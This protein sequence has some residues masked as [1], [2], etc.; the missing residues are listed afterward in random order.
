MLA[1]FK[2]AQEILD[3]KNVNTC[4]NM[5]SIT[6]GN[7]LLYKSLINTKLV[8]QILKSRKFAGLLNYGVW[9]HFAYGSPKQAWKEFHLQRK[10][11]NFTLYSAQKLKIFNCTAVAM[12]YSDPQE[13]FWLL[14]T[15]RLGHTN[16]KSITPPGPATSCPILYSN[17]QKE[18]PKN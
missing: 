14:N 7:I 11:W 15:N 17:Q 9:W 5:N 16:I 2:K 12:Q 1:L 10:C 6:F 18:N 13:F 3:N 8:K 4:S